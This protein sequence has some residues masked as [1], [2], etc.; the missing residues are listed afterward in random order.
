MTLIN[1][2][3]LSVLILNYCLCCCLLVEVEDFSPQDV[4]LFFAAADITVGFTQCFN[5][6]IT[7]DTIVEAVERIEYGFDGSN[8]SSG[9]ILGAAV[10]FVIFDDDGK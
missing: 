1:V 5:V 2:K 4:S 8:P 9:V 10:N 7:N 6:T 3:K